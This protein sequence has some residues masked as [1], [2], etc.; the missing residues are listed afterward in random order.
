[1]YRWPRKDGFAIL[2]TNRDK[3]NG[4]AI[5]LLEHRLMRGMLSA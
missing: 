5:R 2:G 4:R 1:M 3:N